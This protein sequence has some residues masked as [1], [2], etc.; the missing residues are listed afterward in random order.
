MIFRGTLALYNLLNLSDFGKKARKK[1]NSG[2]HGFLALRAE[3]GAAAALGHPGD[4]RLAA[5]AGLSRPAVDQ[6]LKLK[7]ARF[8]PA[9]KVVTH[10]GAP[11]VD[12]RL[13]NAPGLLEQPLPMFPG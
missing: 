12:G 7:E 6:Q 1:R 11:F 4:G 3:K 9:V 2:R 13:K 5:P 8:P 10:R